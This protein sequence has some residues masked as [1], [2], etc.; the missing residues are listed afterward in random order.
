MISSS[1]SRLFIGR[2]SAF[3]LVRGRAY[4]L[5]Q[6]GICR[7]T[8]LFS[9]SYLI[10]LVYQ[11]EPVFEVMEV[12]I[13]LLNHFECST[14]DEARVDVQITWRTPVMYIRSLACPLYLESSCLFSNTTGTQSVMIAQDLFDAKTGSQSIMYV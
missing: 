11:E 10:A 2:N 14:M 6:E 13:I 8:R 9:F 5:L 12:G 1:P 4:S 3:R 7:H